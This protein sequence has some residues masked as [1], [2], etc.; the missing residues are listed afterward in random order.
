MEAPSKKCKNS[1]LEM[2]KVSFINVKYNFHKGLK[3]QKTNF[4][5]AK[6]SENVNRTKDWG[7]IL[8]SQMGFFGIRY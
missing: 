3:H 5:G 7:K 1:N 6:W 8:N 4:L 2:D